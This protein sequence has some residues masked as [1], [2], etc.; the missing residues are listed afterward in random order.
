MLA[1][2]EAT[3]A[4]S[5]GRKARDVIVEHGKHFGV[6]VCQQVSA[7]DNWEIDRFGGG[8]TTAGVGGAL[9]GR[10]ADL[11][12]LD[13]LIKNAEESLSP[14]IREKHWDWWQSTAST[15]IEPGGSVLLMMTRWHPEDLAGRILMENP[16]EWEVISLPALAIHD[17]PMGRAEGEALWPERWNVESLQKLK[18]SIDAYWW[19][20][21]Y[22]QNPSRSGRFEWPDEYFQDIWCN[23][24]ILTA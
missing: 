13:D 14:T 24:P 8:M 4:A 1:S 10:G 22:Q 18:G 6:K 23:A 17:D 9:T 3:F 2:Y 21:M 7:A 15:R 12:I 16:D 20:A 11:M 5:W 19:Q